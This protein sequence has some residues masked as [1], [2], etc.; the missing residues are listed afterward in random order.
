GTRSYLFRYG[1][2][3]ENQWLGLGSVADKPL[4][5]ARD[6][7]AELRALVRRGGDPFADREQRATSPKK[8][9]RRR[10]LRNALIGTSRR[11]PRLEER[12]AHR[13]VG[14]HHPDVREPGHWQAPGRQGRCRPRHEG[15]G[16]DLSPKF[17]PVLRRVLGLM[18][19]PKRPVF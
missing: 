8:A 12:E 16:A 18:F 9:K 19:G 7:A 4:S 6:E 5:E 2:D 14:K 13:P 3:G 11:I 15:A 10:P 17:P 1:R